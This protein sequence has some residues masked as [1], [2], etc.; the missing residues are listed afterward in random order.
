VVAFCLAISAI[1]EL[2][3]WGVSAGTGA[4]ADAFLG[5]QGDVWDPQKDMALAFVGAILAQLLLSRTHDRAIGRVRQES[6]HAN[7]DTE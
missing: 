5:T 3:E 4:A 1:W 2:L 7:S 6:A